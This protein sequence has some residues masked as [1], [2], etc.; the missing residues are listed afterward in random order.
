MGKFEKK[1]EQKNEELLRTVRT[2]KCNKNDI[3]CIDWLLVGIGPI[4]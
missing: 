4:I 1:R 3:F 2:A